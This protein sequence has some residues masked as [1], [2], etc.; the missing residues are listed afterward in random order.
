LGLKGEEILYVELLRTLEFERR[1][2]SNQLRHGMCSFQVTIDAEAE[3]HSTRMNQP[4]DFFKVS[5]RLHM[6]E[7]VRSQEETYKR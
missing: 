6:A 2:R 4:E 5:L 1:I 3:I 7:L